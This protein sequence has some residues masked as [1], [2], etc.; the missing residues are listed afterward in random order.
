MT[1]EKEIIK[2]IKLGYLL[3]LPGD[4]DGKKKWPLML[5]LHGAGERGDDLELVKRHGIPM[6]CEKDDEFPFIAVSP[7]CPQGSW[8]DVY[9]DDLYHLLQHIKLNYSIDESRI[10]L[11]GLSMGGFGTWDFAA[12]HPEEFAAIMPVCGGSR[13][14]DRIIN[15][16]G[17]PVWT[18]HGEL[19]STISISSTE[20]LVNLLN[21]NGGNVKFTRYPDVAHDSHVRAYETGGLYD[22][23]LSHKK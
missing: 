19:D 9:F 14:I 13:D 23:F 2:K 20:V 12:R 7:Q 5:F 21:E 4:Y 11:T 1:F 15:L 17:V 18:F 16:V 8:W 22:W 10:Y 6:I 3:H